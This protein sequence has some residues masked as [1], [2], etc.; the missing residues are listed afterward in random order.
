MTSVHG[1]AVAGGTF[2]AQIWHDFMVAAIGAG[3]PRQWPLP[4]NP[5]QWHAFQ[6]Q[7][8]LSGE[9]S[10]S[11]VLLGDDDHGAEDDD[12]GA[13]DGRA[14][15]AAEHDQSAAEHDQ[16]AA[17]HNGAE[18]APRWLTSPRS[19]TQSHSSS[20]GRSPCRSRPFLWPRLPGAFSPR[21][22]SRAPTCRR[23]AARRW[24][25]SRS[26]PATLRS[27]R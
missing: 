23:F 6:G 3:E 18:P 7:Y 12:V 14:T 15:S 16:S 19:T 4:K 24:T 20:S 22:R 27:R 5:V 9:E 21:T 10:T 25:A 8:A 26:L 1:I 17:H 2:P 11:S 13:Y